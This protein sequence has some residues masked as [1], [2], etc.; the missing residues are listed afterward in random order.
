MRKRETKE[1]GTETHPGEGV[2]KVNFP[3]TRKPSHRQVFEEFWN[4]RGKH[5]LEGKKIKIKKI[6]PT[7]Y[8]PNCKC[9]WRNS[10]DACGHHQPAR[11]GQGG[12]S[13]MLRVRT[14]PECPE[15]NLRELT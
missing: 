8:M 10:P 13:C 12:T 5:N 11:A 4:L 9:Q 7:E 15:D 6:K 2:V 3:S 14:R 1:L